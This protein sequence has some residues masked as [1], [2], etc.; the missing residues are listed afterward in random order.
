MKE[1]AT[2]PTES[3]N[4]GA[5]LSKVLDSGVTPASVETLEKMLSLYERVQTKDAEKQFN[6]SF[7]ALQNELP[8]IVAQTV[9]PNRGKY[10][11]FEDVMHVLKPLLF[12]Y[13]FSV[14]FA[15]Q[16]DDKRI[17]VT[18]K[19]SHI[20]GHSQSTA[21]AVRLGGKADSDVQADCKASTTAKRN[22]LLQAFNIVIRQDFLQEEENPANEGGYITAK[23]ASDLADWVEATDSD[24]RKFLDFAGAD[25]FETIHA[26]R[27]NSLHALL[28]AKENKK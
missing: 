3:A 19:V 20:A 22:A 8:E 28:R 7:N 1:L 9:I 27:L 6:S 18:C 4:I 23:Q 11:R 10:Q 2:I 15:Q 12:K 26:G 25:A 5:M 24:V 17:S 14:S 21:F 16:A 13:G